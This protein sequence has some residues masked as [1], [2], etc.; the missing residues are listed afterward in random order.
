MRPLE[1]ITDSMDMSLSKLWDLLMDKEAWGAAV[2][3]VTKS[4]TRLSDYTEM[5]WSCFPS[6]Q[7]DLRPNYGRYNMAII[8]R[9]PSKGLTPVLLAPSTAVFSGPDPAA[10]HYCPCLLQI[11]GHS[12]ASLGQSFVGLPFLSPGSWCTG[13]FVFAL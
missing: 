8:T 2:H 6:L 9:P 13:G 11:P 10:G 3:G 7:F 12:Q 5:N 4:S 1:G